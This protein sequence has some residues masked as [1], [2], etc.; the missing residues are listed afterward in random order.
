MGEAGMEQNSWEEM[1]DGTKSNR[2]RIPVST[3]NLISKDERDY[4]EL[5]R[6]HFLLWY[7]FEMGH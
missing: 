4:K 1:F 3:K 5:E 6:L 2:N 7:L